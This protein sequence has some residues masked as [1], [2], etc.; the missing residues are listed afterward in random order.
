[1]SQIPWWWNDI[2]SQ[3][4]HDCV[5]A[6]ESRR[7]TTGLIVQDL[8]DLLARHLSYPAIVVVN[9]GTSALM[10]SLLFAGVGPG[11]NVIVPAMTWI[12]TAQAARLLG[13]EVKIADISRATLNLDPD[14]VDQLVDSRTKAIVPVLFNGR[15]GGLE[16]IH[17]LAGR[18]G[19][20]VIEDRCKAL[21]TTF[22]GHKNLGPGGLATFSMGMISH[23]SVGYGGFVACSSEAQAQQIRLIRD[24]GIVR[25]NES[26]ERLG[27]NFKLS[28]FVASLA[29]SQVTLLENRIR[30][31]NAVER[32]YA[33]SLEAISGLEHLGVNSVNP[34]DAGTYH[35]GLLS[36]EY[37]FSDFAQ[38]CKELHVGVQSYHPSLS[39]AT[40]LGSPACENADEIARRIVI[41]PSG[42]TVDE[43][44]V[45]QVDQR[46]SQALDSLAKKLPSP[47]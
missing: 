39:E 18:N 28:D 43:I 7:M 27:G 3:S 36:E 19:I 33:K 15:S 16:D 42:N 31:Q 29:L 21:G 17:Q 34:G 10:A 40:Y 46:I 37:E 6:L 4:V 1:M 41:F 14:H 24:H 32:A 22:L 9:S 35:E 26:Y 23:I 44:L 47:A 25:H 20:T 11:D 45:D 8:E 38:A 12:A 13:A 30:Q 5:E 2:P